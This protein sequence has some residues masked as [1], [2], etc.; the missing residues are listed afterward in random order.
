M[1]IGLD[2]R[3]DDQIQKIWI[4]F[5]GHWFKKEES[6]LGVRLAVRGYKV[7]AIEIANYKSFGL[8]FF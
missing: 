7:T 5:P 2:R 1:S 3:C 4:N 6:A 8:F